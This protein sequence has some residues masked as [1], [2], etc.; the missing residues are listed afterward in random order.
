MLASNSIHQAKVYV[1]MGLF[2]VPCDRLDRVVCC[3]YFTFLEVISVILCMLVLTT[4]F[5]YVAKKKDVEKK[6]SRQ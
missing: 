1:N 2:L 3:G 6:R 4:L 5:M